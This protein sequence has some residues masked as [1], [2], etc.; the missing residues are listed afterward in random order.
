MISFAYVILNGVTGKVLTYNKIFG[1]NTSKL[2]VPTLRRD[3]QKYRKRRILVHAIS[4]LLHR[5]LI[6]FRLK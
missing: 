1:N 6:V 4:C 5:V 3:Y 2:V